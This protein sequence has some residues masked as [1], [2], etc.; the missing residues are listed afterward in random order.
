M[1]KEIAKLFVTLGLEDSGFS[2]SLGKAQANIS[3]LSKQMAIAGAAI[4][5]ALGFATK[6]ALDEEIGINRLSTALKAIGEDYASLSVEIEKNINATQAKTNYS[7]DEQRNALVELIGV[8]GTY[9]GAL[10]Q[11]GLATDLAAAKDMDLTSAAKMVGKVAIGQG[12]SIRELKG[13]IDKGAS[14]TE[15]LAAMQ[16]RFAGAAEGAANPLKQLSNLFHELVVDIGKQLVPLL[17]NLVER[18]LP[19]IQGIRDW[20]AEHP[21]LT[22]VLTIG[23]AILGLMLTGLGTLGWALPLIAKGLT[24]VINLLHLKALA[25]KIVTAAQWLWNTAMSANPIGLIIIGVAALAA[26]IYALAKNWNSIISFFIGSSKAVRELTE[27]EKEHARVVKEAAAKV[28]ELSAEQAKNNVNLEYAKEQYKETKDASA[29]YAEEIARLENNLSDTN[30]ELDKAKD[31]LDTIRGSYDAAAQKVKDFEQAIKDANSEL[32]ALSNPHLEG[33]QAFEDQLF[34]IEEQ[35]KQLR[36]Q[37]LQVPEG[38]D[39][40][41]IDAQ[42]AA[43]EKQKEILE[44]QRDI[45][46]DP[47]LRQAKES[48]ET[49]QGLNVEIAPQTV[50]D[51]IA[52]LGKKLAPDG[53][54]TLGL[55]AARDEMDKQNDALQIQLDIVGDLETAAKGYQDR[56]NEIKH[57]VE[58]TLWVQQENIFFLERAISDMQTAIDAVNQSLDEFQKQAQTK[59]GL[60]Y[61]PLPGETPAVSSFA[62]WEGP[63]PGRMGQPQVAVVHGGEII[64]QPGRGGITNTFNISQLVVRE[65]ADVTRIARELYRMQQ[66]RI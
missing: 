62:G 37:K 50:F 33:M 18:I 24:T 14:A 55:A 43:L 65:E 47:I 61:P 54:L 28:K 52:E 36:L 66:V 20:I 34:G 39:T 51:R 32:D 40:S 38:F 4:T 13:V 19:V 46:F 12:G 31:S 64:S 49:I 35:L 63:V 59:G 26:G 25:L 45:N 7:D 53:E 42:I 23:T 17:R 30:Y 5:A 44:L 15:N 1:A 11:L 3:F 48:I 8:T 22:Q 58:D 6:S 16:D 57:I 60:L 41:S 9:Q 27:A 2:K 29:G 10:E 56:L 21:K